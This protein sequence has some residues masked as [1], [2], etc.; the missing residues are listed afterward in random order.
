MKLVTQLLCI[1][2]QG[3]IWTSM[4]IYTINNVIF[5]KVVK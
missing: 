1:S 4:K 5:F 2:L 3:N